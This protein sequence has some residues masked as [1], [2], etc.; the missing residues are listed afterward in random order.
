MRK[1]DRVNIQ[2][3]DDKK[4][5]TKKDNKKQENNIQEM[6][7]LPLLIIENIDYGRDLHPKEKEKHN[8]IK[9]DSEGT[10]SMNI[11]FNCYQQE[12]IELYMKSVLRYMQC[13]IM[14]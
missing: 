4:K 8:Y 3:K 11:A 12:I 1:G 7:I 6:K 14:L 5:E 2:K 13:Q 9:L 10:S